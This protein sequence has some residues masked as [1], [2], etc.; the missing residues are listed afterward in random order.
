MSL[1]VVINSSV[2]FS[3]T[4]SLYKLQFLDCR[5]LMTQA[6]QPQLNLKQS[7]FL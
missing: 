4:L 1:D 6:G 3:S 2:A 7:L 5:A